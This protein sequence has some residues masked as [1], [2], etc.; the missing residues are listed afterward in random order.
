MTPASRPQP[1]G[2]AAILTLSQEL[3]GFLTALEVANGLTDVEDGAEAGM[4]WPAGFEDRFTLITAALDLSAFEQLVLSLALAQ[5]LFPV[6]TRRLVAALLGLAEGELTVSLTPL[7]CLE[8]LEDG[9]PLVFTEDRPLFAWGVVRFGPGLTPDASMRS[10]TVAP[11]VL[12]FLQGHAGVDPELSLLATEVPGGMTLSGSQEALLREAQAFMEGGTEDRGVLLY[13]VDHESMRSLAFR[14]LSGGGRVLELNVAALSAFAG[15][16]QAGLVRALRRDLRLKGFQA[17]LDATGEV[18]EPG[19]LDGVLQRALGAVPGG[20]VVL[21]G[22][23][24]SVPTTRALLPLEVRAP[25]PR[26]QREQWAAGLGVTGEVPLLHQ[27]G[28]QFHLSLDRIDALA[29]EVRVSL[30]KNAGAERR[31]E[32]AWERARVANRRAMG[33]L[34]DRIQAG[35]TWADL[36]LPASDLAVLQQ[37]SAYVKHRSAVYEGLGMAR[38]GRG[39]AITALFSG[40]SGTGKTLSA[41]VLANDLSLDLYRIDLSSTVSKY[42]GE[43]EKNLKRIFDAAEHGGCILLFDEAD[44]VFGKRGEVRDSNDRYANIQVNYLL[45]RLESFNGLAVLTTNMESSMDVAFMRRIQFVLNF[46]MPQAPEREVLW[47][48]AFPSALDTSELDFRRLA[49]ADVSGGNIRSVALN[50]VFLSLARREPL[51]QALVDEA[52]SLEFRK[53]GRLVL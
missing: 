37:I 43:T 8:C 46:R 2:W 53:L 35:A 15:E 10:L 47:R 6:R 49:Q 13:G 11:G 32:A 51:S 17:A 30:P 25:T 29:N 28:D 52:L 41:E 18:P 48:Q 50:A 1:S 40:P 9:D 23:P 16:E 20:V 39:R 14:L 7:A 33:S 44:S 24:L 31:L 21:S 12:M 5:E 38:P 3:D 19:V 36:V 42:I 34:A 45:Q 27:L 22:S 26:E 4:R